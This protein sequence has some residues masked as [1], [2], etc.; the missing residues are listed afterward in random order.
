MGLMEEIEK[1][2][3]IAKRLESAKSVSKMS[4]E[5]LVV[6]RKE[7]EMLKEKISKFHGSVDA[8]SS[9]MQVLEEENIELMKENKDLRKDLSDAKDQII[10]LKSKGGLSQSATSVA[11]V[12]PMKISDGVE[13]D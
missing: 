11:K 5:E 3:A 6:L 10:S 2:D 9:E 12:T 7:N 13:N 4:K 8:A 1:K